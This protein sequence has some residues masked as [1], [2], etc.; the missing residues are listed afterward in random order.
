MR[1]SLQMMQ[2]GMLEPPRSLTFT[3][4]TAKPAESDETAD[5]ELS[6]A[7]GMSTPPPM[8]K[9]P[10][11]IPA[12][13]VGAVADKNEVYVDGERV[14]M[15]K[16]HTAARIRARSSVRQSISAFFSKIKPGRSGSS[17]SKAPNL[18]EENAAPDLVVGASVIAAGY[19][20]GRLAYYGPHKGGK[21][22]LRCGVVLDRPVGKN[23][24]TVDGHVYFEC[25]PMHGV[26]LLPKKV[27][28]PPP[29]LTSVSG[30]ES[31]RQHRRGQQAPK[32]LSIGKSL[33]AF[34][35][36]PE[37]A[38]I[39]FVEA[40]TVL[41]E[42]E[43]AA[44]SQFEMDV[45]RA[46]TDVTRKEREAMTLKAKE[47]IDAI[48]AARTAAKQG[49]TSVGAAGVKAAAAAIKSAVMD[50]GEDYSEYLVID[51][52]ET[53]EE[54]KRQIAAA[55]VL[56]DAEQDLS[57]EQL[58]SLVRSKV[59][60]CRVRMKSKGD[61][62]IAKARLE[63]RTKAKQELVEK[64]AKMRS[65]KRRVSKAATPLDAGAGDWAVMNHALSD[66]AES[67]AVIS[68]KVLSQKAK[69]AD[70]QSGLD[71]INA[72]KATSI[73][74]S[75]RPMTRSPTPLERDFQ[76]SPQI[77]FGGTPERPNSLPPAEDIKEWGM[78]GSSP[79]VYRA[80]QDYEGSKPGYLGFEAGEVI[81][82]L[83]KSPDGTDQSVT[84]I[85]KGRVMGE[86][87]LFPSSYVEAVV[88]SNDAAPV[89]PAT[90]GM[91]ARLE[92]S[93]RKP[94]SI[95]DKTEVPPPLTFHPPPPMFGDSGGMSSPA[96][97]DWDAG[98]EIQVNTNPSQRLK[99]G[100][101]DPGIV[102]ETEVSLAR[103]PNTDTSVN[104]VETDL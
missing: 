27:S 34:S 88:L 11:G 78:A 37:D 51:G 84:K 10:R 9:S 4:G 18:G 61:A 7:K 92:T 45:K 40:G 36:A 30:P 96:S 33:R 43:A 53:N 13:A 24:G 72:V 104:M 73:S 87:G 86:E 58:T 12:G 14:Q 76:E 17:G 62:L 52:K 77:F 82:I 21:P 15:R 48:R 54:E 103:S 67:E 74:D 97:P 38:V 2:I 93:A 35:I 69:D 85:W 70:V 102:Q 56:Y 71:G 32:P 19:G 66:R 63:A 100:L 8:R 60:A 79:A 81:E 50:D 59:Q 83:S 28:L 94:M 42:A 55:Q 5:D 44:I 47:Y 22:G 90:P 3:Q 89:S 46:C 98:P 31:P 23:N 1:S 99:T 68:S 91:M 101:A 75:R 20:A 57:V 29:V 26:L 80:V 64:V 65:E 6:I 95:A 49:R 39:P 41:E 25:G 16:S